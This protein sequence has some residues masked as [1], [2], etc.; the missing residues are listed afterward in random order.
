MSADQGPVPQS[1]VSVKTIVIPILLGLTQ[2]FLDFLTAYTSVGHY[3]PVTIPPERPRRTDGRIR[4]DKIRNT[5]RR[6][7]SAHRG[8]IST[9]WDEAVYI[10]SE[11]IYP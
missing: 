8:I 6:T 7:S 11:Y 4:H 1:D 10:F 9:N 3:Q 5:P 2:R